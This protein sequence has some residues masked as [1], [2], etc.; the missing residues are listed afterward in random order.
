[1]RMRL[2]GLPSLLSSV[3]LLLLITLAFSSNTAGQNNPETPEFSVQEHYTK[4]E[5]RIP[6]RDAV[7][8]FTSVYLPQDSSQAYP[9]L[10]NRSPY[11][12][13]PYGVDQY[14]ETLGPAAEFD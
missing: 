14:R 5:Y 3:F 10:I 4:Y 1:M 6:M 11:S 8:L 2:R 9:F 13:G 12:G 7:H